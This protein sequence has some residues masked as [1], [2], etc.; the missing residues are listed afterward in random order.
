[1]QKAVRK[2]KEKPSTTHPKMPSH[3]ISNHQC[4][5]PET[6]PIGN[7]PSVNPVHRTH[8]KDSHPKPTSDRALTPSRTSIWSPLT[9]EWEQRRARSNNL[10]TGPS[11]GANPS[12]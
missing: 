1:M 9:I 8:A 12:I 6:D 7:P 4:T 2:P 3:Q 10:P 5:D 11:P